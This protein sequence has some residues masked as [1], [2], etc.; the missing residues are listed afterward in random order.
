MENV[1]YGTNLEDALVK[2]LKDQ[3]TSAATTNAFS[4]FVKRMDADG[5]NQN[6]V[7]KN[8]SHKLV[9]VSVLL[10]IAKTANQ[11]RLVLLLEKCL[12]ILLSI[13]YGRD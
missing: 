7:I 13:K 11:G 10:L 6:L 2:N 3:L 8:I 1:V 5:G 12:V 4:D 9:A